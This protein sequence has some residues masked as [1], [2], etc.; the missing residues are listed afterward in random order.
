MSE[1]ATAARPG[2]MI[3]KAAWRVGVALTISIVVGLLMMHGWNSG[4]I[5]LFLRTIIVGLCAAAAFAL[6]EVW[7]RT[8]PRWVQRWAL[9]VI[10]VG[11]CMPLATLLIYVLSTPRGAP[12]FWEVRDRWTGG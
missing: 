9:Q 1:L 12:P 2:G 6:F 10:A 4:A 3:V 11:A 5:S 8:L 7:P